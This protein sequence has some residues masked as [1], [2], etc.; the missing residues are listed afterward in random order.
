MNQDTVININ[1]RLW[2]RKKKGQ[3]L[4]RMMMVHLSQWAS[5]WV[6][7]HNSTSTK[8]CYTHDW[9]NRMWFLFCSIRR[10]R[11]FSMFNKVRRIL[12]DQKEDIRTKLCFSFCLFRSLTPEGSIHLQIQVDSY[13]ARDNND[14]KARIWKPQ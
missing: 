4:Q 6:L 12:E 13:S 1:E 8:Q 2:I 7:M 9:R 3:I 14:G 10:R 5:F 11:M